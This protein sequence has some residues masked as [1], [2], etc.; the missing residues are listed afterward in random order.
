MQ[1]IEFA[2]F[3][4]GKYRVGDGWSFGKLLSYFCCLLHREKGQLNQ[5]IYVV[6]FCAYSRVELQGTIKWIEST[7]EEG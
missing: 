7:Y 5:R 6:Y 2:I 4:E 3:I 1:N